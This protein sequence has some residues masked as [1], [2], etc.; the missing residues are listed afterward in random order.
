MELLSHISLPQLTW[1]CFLKNFQEQE[2]YP[3][4]QIP[5]EKSYE[6]S[7]NETIYGGNCQVFKRH[8]EVG[9]NDVTFIAGLDMNNLYGWASSRNL[10]YGKP[11]IITE[12]TSLRDKFKSISVQEREKPIDDRYSTYCLFSSSSSSSHYID[13]YDFTGFLCCSLYFTPEQKELM[14]DFPPLPEKEKVGDDIVE[15]MVYSVKI[16]DKYYISS[17]MLKYLLENNWVTLDQIW[18]AVKYS[19]G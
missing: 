15:K 19:I 13:P 3:L 1:Q 6:L 16:K 12:C 8:A 14:K 5:D 18:E 10:P 4:Y 11:T 7:F 9:C 2:K 17:E